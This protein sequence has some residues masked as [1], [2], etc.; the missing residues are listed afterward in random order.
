MDSGRLGRARDGAHLLLPAWL[1]REGGRPLQQHRP[2]AGGDGEL[3][4]RKKYADDHLIE[5]MFAPG[6]R[7][8]KLTTLPPAMDRLVILDC[9]GVLVDSEPLSNRTLSQALAAI[10]VEM[11]QDECMRTFMGRSFTTVL[12]EIERRLGAPAPD[13]FEADYRQRM[14]AAFAA[15]LRAV[16]GVEDALDRIEDPTCVAS[17]GR[18]EKI[19]FTLG[20]TGLLP[21]FEGRIFSASEVPR[22]KPHPDL[23]LHAAARMGFAPGHVVV[24]EDSRPGVEAAQAAGMR[25]LGYAGRTDPDDLDGAEIFTDMAALPELL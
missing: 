23:F 16:P 13:T 3:E 9:D 18:P 12:D 10:G 5:H 17:S 6:V 25:V 7:G 20:H 2:T 24:V 4:T 21:R 1:R 22:G 8:G 15:E 14:F 19:R 11:S